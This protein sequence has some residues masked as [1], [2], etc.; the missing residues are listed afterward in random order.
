MTP[1]IGG[2]WCHQLM[3]MWEDELC[4][5][6]W[7]KV[8][9]RRLLKAQ[10]REWQEVEKN[11]KHVDFLHFKKSSSD[12]AAA[13]LA[14]LCLRQHNNK[15]VQ[16]FT[17][18][19]VSVARISRVAFDNYHSEAAGDAADFAGILVHKPKYWPHDRS[20]RKGQGLPKS[21]QFIL[22]DKISWQSIP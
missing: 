13:M 16:H 7:R 14:R 3:K 15:V 10:Q 5:T 2:R 21:L 18:S 20:R 22:L 12:E 4:G 19:T 1:L 8:M 11:A 9:Q 17:I 6:H